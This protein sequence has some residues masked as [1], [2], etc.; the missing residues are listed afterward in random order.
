ME[1]FFVNYS[2][3]FSHRCGMYPEFIEY[4]FERLD[5]FRARRGHASCLKLVFVQ[6]EQ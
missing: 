2:N 4:N 6:Y 5:E 3:G 1:S